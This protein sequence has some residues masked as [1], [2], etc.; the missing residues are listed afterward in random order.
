MT[1]EDVK[2]ILSN[3]GNYIGNINFIDRIE[4]ENIY[5]NSEQGKKGEGNKELDMKPQNKLPDTIS[6]D[7]IPPELQIT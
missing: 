3:G 7:I 6:E 4:G 2:I 5:L 1:T